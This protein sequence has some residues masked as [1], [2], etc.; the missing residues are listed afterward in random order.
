MFGNATYHY[1]M[2]YY[3][4]SLYQS[5]YLKLVFCSIYKCIELDI[6]IILICVYSPRDNNDDVFELIMEDDLNFFF[7]ILNR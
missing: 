5:F 4:Y 2:S 3:C 1:F 6:Y 7:L